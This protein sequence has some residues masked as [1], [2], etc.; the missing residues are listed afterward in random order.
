M[1]PLKLMKLKA[2][3]ETFQTSHPQFVS[4]LQAVYPGGVQVGAV[5]DIS[6]TP[7]NSKPLRYHMTVN[8]QDMALFREMQELTKNG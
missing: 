6:V 7:P 3:W 4:F 1:N 5:L 2:A 8:E